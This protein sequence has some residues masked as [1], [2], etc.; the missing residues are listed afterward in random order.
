MIELAIDK[1]KE[2]VTENITETGEYVLVQALTEIVEE[3]TG[4]IS[5]KDI[6]DKMFQFYDDEQKW[7]NTKWIGRALGRLGFSDKRRVGTGIEYQLS[8]KTVNDTANRLQIATTQSSQTTQT[9]LKSEVNEVS[10]VSEDANYN[11]EIKQLYKNFGANIPKS[12]LK[13]IPQEVVTKW[14][15]DGTIMDSGIFFYVMRPEDF[16]VN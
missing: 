7:L 1:A 14:L 11:N 13:N 8:V 4:Y 12:E 9:T 6:R 10:V 2:R 5:V 15:N 3:K 16:E